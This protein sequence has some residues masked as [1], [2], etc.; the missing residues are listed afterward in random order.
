MANKMQIFLE[1]TLPE[2]YINPPAESGE[3]PVETIEELMAL[4]QNKYGSFGQIDF[5]IYKEKDM[6]P[7]IKAMNA[8][9]KEMGDG[10]KVDARL[11]KEKIGLLVPMLVVDGKII[12]RGTYP[13]LTGMRGGEN[14]ISRGG[15]GHH[16]H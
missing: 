7:F 8:L 1:E 11:L 3:K 5:H 10:T 6:I 9:F 15:T 4:Y 13:D 12:S 2:A 14:S 16:E